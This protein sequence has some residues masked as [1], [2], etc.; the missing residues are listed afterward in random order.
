MKIALTYSY[1]GSKFSGSQTQPHQNAVEDCLNHALNHVG[2][3]TPV[4]SSS[5]TDKGVHAI[6]QVSCVECGEFWQ[7]RLDHLRSQINKHSA[8][9]IRVKSMQVVSENFHPR[10]D[11]TARSY[12][13]I[14]SHDEPS[15]FLSD[16]LYFADELNLHRLNLALKCFAGVHDFKPFYKVGSDEKSTIRE[17]YHAFAYQIYRAKSGKLS[18]KFDPN[19][20]HQKPNFTVIN[21]KA[22]GFLRA[23]VRLMVANSIE[24]SKSD[25]NLAKFISNFQANKPL[26]RIPAP[27]NGLYLKRVFY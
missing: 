19:L 25:E 3:F 22:N 20:S 2:I 14:I 7:G 13:Y 6:A 26:T 8:P 11:A 5:R 4:I 12:R 10:Y 15:V 18:T 16:Y 1:D 9:Y 23:Q 21:F 27:P 17:I 24:A